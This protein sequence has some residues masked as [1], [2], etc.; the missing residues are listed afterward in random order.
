MVA[1]SADTRCSLGPIDALTPWCIYSF[2][3]PFEWRSN[4]PMRT[5]ASK[6]LPNPCTAVH[7]PHNNR[8]DCVYSN[9]IE[10]FLHW[11]L[12]KLMWKYGQIPRLAWI[13]FNFNVEETNHFVNYLVHFEFSIA[14][15]EQSMLD[16]RTQQ[17]RKGTN[18]RL[19]SSPQLETHANISF[20]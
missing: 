2:I 11:F 15:T 19:L 12:P 18:K 8:I 10:V 16:C 4:K 14:R 6:C 20:I 5:M 1:K 9:K 7:F 3:H 13:R 17:M